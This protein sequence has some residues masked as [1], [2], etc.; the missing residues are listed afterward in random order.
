[1]KVVLDSWRDFLMSKS[2]NA[3][4]SPD[5]SSLRP[6][7]EL[8]KK[9]FLGSF[10][11]MALKNG[12]LPF[13]LQSR[14]THGDVFKLN[15]TPWF[16]WYFVAHPD[17]VERVLHGNYKNFPKGILWSRLKA[18]LGDGL[19]TS[20]GDKWQHHRRAV[21]THFHRKYYNEYSDAMLPSIARMKTRWQKKIGQSFDITGEMMRL[22]LCNASVSLFGLD[23]DDQA[24]KIGDDLAY[25]LDYVHAGVFRPLNS[26]AR[27][28]FNRSM[29]GLNLQI[30]R[31]I[32][33][34]RHLE[35][36]EEPQDLLQTLLT[37]QGTD[38]NKLTPRQLHDEMMTFIFTGHET[39]AIGLSWMWYLLS[40]HPQAAARLHEEVDR[41]LDGRAPT[42]DD[43]PNLPYTKMVFQE[44]MRLYP[45]VWGVAR[46]TV[47]DEEIGGF[48]VPANRV[49]SVFPY[50]THRHPDF[51]PNP[52]AFEPERFTPENSV[53]RPKYA[54]FPFGGGARQCIGNQFAMHEAILVTASVAQSYRLD[55]VPGHP[56]EAMSATTLRPRH[57]ILMTLHERS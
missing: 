51:W 27:A 33:K 57:G 13:Y 54:Y 35:D 12:A 6:F 34:R 29:R 50:V 8:P 11:Y 3:A 48:H 18:V 24:D 1:M 55:V 26:R 15:Y 40:L 49:I 52:E 45:P 31:I 14:R 2:P 7:P 38:G 32:E 56:V 9:P 16:E 42:H 53:G 22:T 46:Q 30:K 10:P 17:N 37:L 5:S 21:Q 43:L 19:L 47:K 39:T 36:G 41:V 25:A 4:V 28:K 20:D 44:A 23:L